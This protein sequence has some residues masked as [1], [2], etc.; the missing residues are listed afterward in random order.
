[1]H[2]QQNIKIS[3]Q[4]SCTLSTNTPDTRHSDLIIWIDDVDIRCSC[5]D[6]NTHRTDGLAVSFSPITFAT[7]NNCQVCT[8]H[9]LA[10]KSTNRWQ[11][12][13]VYV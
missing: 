9:S 10:L 4:D 7:S 12:G 1:M 3:T 8:V 13:C 5:T 11:E 2:G 6:S